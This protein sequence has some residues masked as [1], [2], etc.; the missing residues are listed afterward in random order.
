MVANLCVE[1]SV[2]ERGEVRGQ[3]CLGLAEGEI[4]KTSMY[5]FEMTRNDMGNAIGIRMYRL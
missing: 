3:R 1:L 2:G 5:I 4:L